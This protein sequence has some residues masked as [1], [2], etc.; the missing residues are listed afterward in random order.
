MNIG[1]N[2]VFIGKDIQDEHF[3]KFTY[4]K[5]YRISSFSNLPDTEFHGSGFA[6]LFDNFQYGCLGCYFDRY[7]VSIDDF[8]D[9]NIQQIIKND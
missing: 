6:I 2:Y 9:K 5:T 7:F 8:R 4:G 1:D 3:S